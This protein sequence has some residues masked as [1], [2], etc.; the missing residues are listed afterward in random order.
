VRF[1][2]GRLQPDGAIVDNDN[3][4]DA[5]RFEPHYAM[6]EQ[7][8]QVQIYEDIMVDS[9][10]MPTT[11]LLKGVRYIKDNR[12]LPAGMLKAKAEEAI[13][14]RGE[15]V[16][17]AD[18]D[19]GGDRVIYRVRVGDAPGPLRVEAQLLFQSIGYRW[20]QNL[21]PYEAAE[22]RRFVGYYEATAQSSAVRVT[23]ASAIDD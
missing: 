7:A 6:I 22:T 11:G 10:G 16:S 1:E 19:D 12:L 17:D 9:A 8:D 15:A 18:F 21:K 14:V 20:A 23:S 2:S 13:A 3:D 5:A 4:V